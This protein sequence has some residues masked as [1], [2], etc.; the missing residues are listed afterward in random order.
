M[1]YTRKTAMYPGTTIDPVVRCIRSYSIIDT[2]IP[3]T[4][5]NRT[6]SDEKR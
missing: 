2:Q 1:G 5:A 6:I 4:K 3:K